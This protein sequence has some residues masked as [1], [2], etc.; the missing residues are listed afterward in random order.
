MLLSRAPRTRKAA[1]CGIASRSTTRSRATI[2]RRTFARS[3]RPCSRCASSP[4][5]SSA[6]TS[7]VRMKVSRRWIKGAIVHVVMA[8]PRDSLDPY[9]WWFPIVGRVP[10]RGYFNESDATGRGGVAGG[11]GP[12]HDGA[13]GGGVLEPWIFRRS[14]ADES[15]QTRSRRAGGRDHPRAVPSHVLPRERRDVRRVG[16]QLCRQRGRGRVFRGD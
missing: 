1:S 5:S 13:A 4:L 12:R 9:T 7:A 3:S 16:R 6:R 11:E 14:V 8:A 2:C 15:A 10:Y